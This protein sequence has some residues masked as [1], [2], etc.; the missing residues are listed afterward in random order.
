MNRS[1]MDI[2]PLQ[3][4]RPWYRL[5]VCCQQRRRCQLLLGSA[6]QGV[7]N[8]MSAKN[9]MQQAFESQAQKE[10]DVINNEHAKRLE[11]GMAPEEATELY[12]TTP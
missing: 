3:G 12:P 8:C 4:G 7:Q 9:T 5:P 11:G 1:R 6:A 10:I 2:A